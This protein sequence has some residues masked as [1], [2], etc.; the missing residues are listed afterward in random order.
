MFIKRNPSGYTQALPGVRL[1]P[2][3]HGESML[4]TEFLLQ[5][6]Y[7]LPRHAHPNEQTGYLVSGRIRLTI[8]EET[9]DLEPG[10]SWDVPPNVIHGAEIL[11]DA[12]AVE[13]FSPV[14]E[15]YLALI[16]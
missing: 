14:R 12:V 3:A 11:E 8:G 2:L 15:D 7:T 10:D 5:K 16:K 9:R 13:V 4:L 6:G 1:K